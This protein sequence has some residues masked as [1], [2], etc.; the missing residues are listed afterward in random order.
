MGR[1]ISRLT[2][3]AVGAVIAL[4]FLAGPVSAATVITTFN[5]QL[6]SLVAIAWDPLTGNVFVYADSS[7]LIREYGPDGTNIDTGIARPGN[8][9]ND[10]DLDFAL[11]DLTVAGQFVKTNALLA[12]NGDDFPASVTALDKGSGNVVARL[13]LPD[14][15]TPVG[16]AHH[17]GRGS[18][19]VADYVEDDLIEIDPNTGAELSRFDLNPTGAPFFDLFYGD[20]DV[21]PTTGNLWVVSSSQ[22]LMREMTPTG[23]YVGDV[24]LT[25]LNLPAMAGLAFESS[26]DAWIS[27][28]SSGSVYLLG[29]LQSTKRPPE[30]GEQGSTCTGDE[31]DE[32]QGTSS[33]DFIFTGA[34]NDEI[35]SGGGNDTIEAGAGDDGIAAGGGADHVEG[36]DGDD[37]ILGDSQAPTHLR[38]LQSGGSGDELDGGEGNDE[39]LGEAGSDDLLGDDGKDELLGGAGEDS[40]KGGDGRDILSGGSATDIL[41]GGPGT[42]TCVVTTKL[43]KRKARNCERFRRHL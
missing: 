32:V 9:S 40:L 21:H 14:N 12:I 6:G 16:M 22:Q 35:S 4:A 23:Q 31:D 43:E 17:P 1:R 42:D 30:C 34:G 3:V 18:L 28:I 37:T 2:T 29:S 5:P 39:I 15:I 25:S 13:A 38:A 27:T 10:F 41:N 7:E 11:S 8:S 20:V 26:G 36:G 19:F 33:A 24:D